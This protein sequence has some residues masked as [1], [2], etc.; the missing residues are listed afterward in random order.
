V[1][2]QKATGERNTCRTG[3]GQE[4]TD[5][6]KARTEVKAEEESN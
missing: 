1:Q 5:Q 2:K 3:D 4:E 6:R